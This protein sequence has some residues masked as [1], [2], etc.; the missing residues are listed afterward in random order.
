[1]IIERLRRQ[2]AMID[3]SRNGVPV[4]NPSDQLVGPKVTLLNEYSASDGDL[5]PYR[6]RDAGLGK[7]VGKRSWGGVIGITGSLPFMDGGELNRP[8]F[9][10]YAKDGSSWII[11][12]YGVD[13][14]IVVDNDPA[15]E[16]RGEDQQLDKAIDVILE[17][18]RT[19]PTS[20]PA[21]PPWPVR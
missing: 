4:P 19:R 5:F 2:V 6:F 15:R 7:L 12:G 11:E 8:E 21:P 20:L 1:M 9:A 16:F 10:K 17:E 14:D 13:P 18:L 3:L